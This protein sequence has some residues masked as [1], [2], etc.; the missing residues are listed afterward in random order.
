LAPQDSPRQL[1]LGALRDLPAVQALM[2]DHA[3]VLES[4]RASEGH[5]RAL[6]DSVIYGCVFQDTS[7]AIV[8]ANTAAE[9]ILGL[10][11]AQMQ[12]RTS[13]DP[14]WRSVH[15]DGSL[16]PGDTHPAI[17]ALRTGKPIQNIIMG[18]FH[19]DKGRTNWIEISAVPLVHPGTDRPYQVFTTFQDITERKR[20]EDARD[21]LARAEWLVQGE[22]FFRALAR[23]LGEHLEMDYVCIDRL[24]G[25]A[26]SA[27]TV[28]VWCDGR[29]DENITYTLKDT[30]CGDV[31]GNDVCF[32]PR[33]VCQLFPRDAAL[34]QLGAESYVGITLWG[35]DGQ[36]TGLIAV[37]GRKPVDEAGIAQS[38]LALVGV[39]AAAEL[40]LRQAEQANRLSESRLEQT[41][42]ASPIGM[43]IVAIDGSFLRVNPAFCAMLGWTSSELHGM[44]FREITHPEDLAPSGQILAELNAG[45][46]QSYETEKRYLN[47][48]GGEIWAQLNVSVVRDGAGALLHFVAQIQDITDRRRSQEALR[49]SETTLR[50]VVEN[51]QDAIGVSRAGIHVMVNPAYVR[52]FGFDAPEELVGMPV[53]DLIDPEYHAFVEQNIR[54]RAA[55][56][57][58]SNTYEVTAVRKDG[59]R[60]DMEV[61]ASLY[62]IGD[63]AFSLVILRDVT[64][65]H[66]AEMLRRQDEARFRTWFEMPLVGICITSP[67]KGWLE[68]NDHLCAMLGY[69][70]DE[71]KS[72]TWADLTHPDDLAADV[73]HFERVLRGEIEGYSLDKRFIRKD[74]SLLPTELKVRAVRTDA[75][76]VDYL[77]ALLIDVTDR[78]RAEQEKARLESQLHQAQKMESV[79]RLAGGVAHDFNNMLSVILGHAEVAL[80]RVEPSQPIHDD[81][82]EILAAATRSADLTRQLLAFA[83]KQTIA[84]RLLDLNETVTGMLAMLQRLI[85]EQIRLEWEPAS[86]LW[87]V[88]VDPSQIDQ[89][90]ANL[91]VN[92]R[93]AIADVGTISIETGNTVLDDAYCAHHAGVQ[94]GE[95]VR[96]I[97]IDDGAG[98]D[99]ET[100]GH[101]FEPFFTTK[102]LGK[103]TGI[104]LA[105]VYGAVKQNHGFLDVSSEPGEGTTFTVYLPRHRGAVVVAA[106]PSDSRSLPAGKETILLVEDEAAILKITRTILE[107]QGYTVLAAASPD[108]AIRLAREHGGDIHLLMTDV[109]MPG[110]NGRDLAQ[111]LLTSRPNLKRLFMSGYTADV[112]GQ[113]GVLDGDVQFIQKP[114]SV[115]DLSAKVRDVLRIDAR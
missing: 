84:P 71:L 58:A 47:K 66:R 52:M 105:T 33:G 23:F 4:L 111:L 1:E 46:R 51:S 56:L 3:R 54:N 16:F 21:F 79:G 104:G 18:V 32:F 112:I 59:T 49:E 60:F 11:L 41:F 81:L 13:L 100:L 55:G 12:G 25:D 92:A 15:A 14:R 38:T 89:I 93:D 30:P 28:A 7:G 76:A 102:A 107:R 88:V 86:N 85:G 77:V 5:Y 9:R 101:L 2:A 27:E 39:R 24:E 57:L 98:M 108:E 103:G 62:R 95:Y 8:S 45:R 82:H 44:T 43:A 75:G 64:D 74:A 22:D 29:F 48:N 80:T 10:S 90:L 72:L 40:E 78:K 106:K 50:A 113:H 70:R 37:I 87:P 97:V 69:E 109:V 67:T 20:L 42:T 61:H 63:Q 91:C 34:Q 96:L 36:P 26:L 53:L 114:F 17:E 115:R 83:R 6:F 99:Q 110:M 31:V 65:R 35:S 68:V 19:P 94:P 73:G